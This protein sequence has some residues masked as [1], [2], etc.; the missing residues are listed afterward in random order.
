MLNWDESFTFR[1]PAMLRSKG[2]ERILFFDLDNYIGRASAAKLECTEEAMPEAMEAEARDE[3]AQ[4]FFYAADEDEDMEIPE[5]NEE[6]E[7]R[8]RERMEQEKRSYGT[9]AFEHSSGSRLPMIDDDG[10][11]DVMA[12]AV[13]LDSDH[14]VAAGTIE[15][16][17]DDML[18]S[19][20]APAEDPSGDGDSE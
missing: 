20:Y 16:L 13:V 2:D 19:L 14:T 8:M 4:G 6:L 17:Q 7:R 5:E 12:E 1:V 18:E 11:W 3:E 10:E 9:P 15:R